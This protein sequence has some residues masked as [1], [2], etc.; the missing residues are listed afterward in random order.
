LD[1]SIFGFQFMQHAI[2]AAMLAGIA[3]S[4]VGV[5]GVL[6]HMPFVSVCMA[7]SAFA[8]ALVALFVG[9]NPLVGAFVFSIIAAGVIGPLADKG[10]LNI[11]TSIGV[12]FSLMLGI[13]FLFL[14]LMSGSR[15]IALDYL[16]GNI[17]TVTRSDLLIL[18]LIVIVVVCLVVI[19]F[20]EL[21][22]VVFSRSVALSLGI[23]AVVITYAILFLT[24]ATVAASLRSVGGLLIFSL[25][26]NPASAAYQLTYSLK[27]MFILAAIFGV[28]SG[29]LWLIISYVFNLPGGAS[30]VLTSSAI[31][32]M[33]LIFS[34]KRRK[35]TINVKV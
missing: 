3:C 26:L 11:D 14:G 6:F 31:F 21:Q 10:E 18:G 24:G 2:I 33:A 30:I 8:G 12:I 35:K 20:K 7:H 17:L 23:P 32:G 25:V 9:F 28:I 15:S 19:F 34:P 13:A 5:F 27:R 1:L 16:W 4:I 22:T 29:W